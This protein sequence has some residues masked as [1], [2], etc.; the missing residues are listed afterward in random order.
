MSKKII[1]LG[2]SRIVDRVKNMGKFGQYTALVLLGL[3]I[4]LLVWSGPLGW[5]SAIDLLGDFI[6]LLGETLNGS[7]T[8]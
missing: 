8:T 3:A 4:G 6:I 2:L 5:P 1:A 7:P